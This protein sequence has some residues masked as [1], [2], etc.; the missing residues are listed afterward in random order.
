MQKDTAGD[1]REGK[2][3]PGAWASAQTQEEVHW[4]LLKLTL[5]DPSWQSPSQS[6]VSKLVFRVPIS[7]LNEGS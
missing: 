4:K 6:P 3:P 1:T 7:S 2:G 5:Q